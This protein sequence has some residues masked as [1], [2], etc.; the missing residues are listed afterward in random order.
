MTT[1]SDDDGFID[2]FEE[3]YGLDMFDKDTDHD[4][5]EPSRK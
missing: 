5:I 1:D 3:F 2:K 4:G